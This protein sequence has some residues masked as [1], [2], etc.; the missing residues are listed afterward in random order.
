MLTSRLQPRALMMLAVLL[1]L[2]EACMQRVPERK[3]HLLS[4]VM[5]WGRKSGLLPSSH[6]LYCDEVFWETGQ[7]LHFFT[8]ITTSLP[9]LLDQLQFA[10]YPNNSTEHTIAHLHHTAMSHLDRKKGNYV[11]MLFVYYSSE[12]KSLIPSILTSKSW[13]LVR[14][15]VNGS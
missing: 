5:T 11:T 4:R 9:D 6:V 2:Q 15:C 7:R 1:A 13:D 3:T 8:D 10:H 12:L 14:P